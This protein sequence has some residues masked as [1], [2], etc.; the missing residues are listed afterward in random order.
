MKIKTLINERPY[1]VLPFSLLALL[2]PVLFIEYQVTRHTGGVFMY[3]V[4]D[5]FIHLSVARDLALH[6]T[7]GI[8]AGEFQSASSSLLY[9]IILASVF[10]IFSVHVSFPFIINIIAGIILIVVLFNRLR[11]EL[12]NPFGQLMTLLAVIFFTPLPIL[13]ISGMEHTLQ[14][15]FA[16]LFIFC[17]SDW[18]EQAVKE[19][20]KT[21]IPASLLIFGV[22]ACTIRYE[23]IFLVAIACLLMLYK[24]KIK[25]A[26]LLGAVCALPIILFGIYSIA[27][28]SYF[29]PN[30]ILMKSEG[31]RLSVGGILHFLFYVVIKKLMVSAPGISSV[32]STVTT[33]HLLIILPLAYLYFSGAVNKSSRYGYTLILLIFCTLLQITLA[34]TG[35]F[36][37]YEAYIVMNSV[38]ILSILIYQNSQEI[39]MR[40]RQHPVIMGFVVFFLLLPVCMR[41][42]SAFSEAS[43]ACI[44]IFEQQ[45]QMAKFLRT[46]YN[47]D[48]IAANDIGAITFF[49]EEKPLD[50]V[51]LTSIKVARSKK[52]NYFSPAF[53]DSLSRS[54]HVAL[55][56]LYD[57]WFS[58]SLLVRWD[59]VATW[60]ISKNVICGD[61]V[62]SFYAIDKDRIPLLK[63]NLQLYQPVL[64]AGVS[65]KYY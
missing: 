44:N 49:K 41:T 48:A 31:A 7:W 47:N 60:T 6:G 39:V 34:A 1:L 14:C 38:F 16:F 63:R 52:N 15:L 51:G 56:V 25:Q 17:F 22:F 11:K 46:Y 65:V 5:T 21:N 45:Y 33:Q 4:D 28:G 57:S 20:G 8:S 19:N 29:L 40:F 55:A 9:T 36:Y 26:F 64:P 50:L 58:D 42:A 18:L 10:K 35:W 32:T 53:L 24:R 3:P 54:E 43:R 62:V 27:K 37:R 2:V 59:K 61:S 13:I 12:I 30:S 23:G